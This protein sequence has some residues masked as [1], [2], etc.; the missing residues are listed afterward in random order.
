[1]AGS[2]PGG[3]RSER[4]A[5]SRTTVALV[6]LAAGIA[7]LAAAQ[8][9]APGAASLNATAT[10][11][12]GGFRVGGTYRIG[13]VNEGGTDFTQTLDPSGSYDVEGWRVWY[14]AGLKLLNYPEAPAPRGSRLVARTTRA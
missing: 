3:C 5:A 9:A 2:R 14:S 12:G 8:W 7:M 13:A 6:M 4:S 10:P 11:S 1:M